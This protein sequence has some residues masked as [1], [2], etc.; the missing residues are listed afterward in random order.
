MQETVCGP[1]L[2]QKIR[3]NWA[4]VEQET[5]QAAEMSEFALE[6]DVDGAKQES[7]DSS[8]CDYNGM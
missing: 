7:E 5:S 2:P 6:D 4:A 1:K 8:D 3:P